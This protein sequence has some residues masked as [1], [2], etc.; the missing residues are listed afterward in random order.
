MADT[1]AFPSGIVES[2]L[3]EWLFLSTGHPLC[4]SP[5]EA[6]CRCP[7]GQT[8]YRQTGYHPGQRCAADPANAPGAVAGVGRK[9]P[10]R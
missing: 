2:V 1:F 4:R 9:S 5:E 10:A 8:Q 3:F 7:S 6:S